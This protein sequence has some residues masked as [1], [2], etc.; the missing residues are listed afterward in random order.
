M[1][2]LFCTG[3]IGEFGGIER[4][5]IVK[6]NAF[7]EALGTENVAIC[8]TDRGYYPTTIHPLSPGIKVYDL[9]TPYWQFA[10]TGALLKGIIPNVLRTRKAIINVVRDFQPDVI[11]ST[12]SYEKFALALIPKSSLRDLTGK[13][14]IKVREFHFNSNYRSIWASSP[15]IKIYARLAESFE[16]HVLPRFYDKSFLLTKSDLTENM[17]NQ[18][19]RFDY[20][21]NPT[22]FQTY[23][24]TNKIDN[25]TVIAVGRFVYQ[26]NFEALIEIWHDV[27]KIHP[28][29]KLRIVGEGALRK[30]YEQL[31]ASLGLTE[32]VELP[33]YSS[34]V[35]SE[36]MK[37]S[38]YAMTSQYEGFG[39]VLL[40]AQSCG[41]PIVSYDLPYG[42][43]EIV[44]NNKDGFIVANKDKKAFA[45]ALNTLIENAELREKMGCNATKNVE[46]FAPDRIINQWL[47]KYRELLD[48]CKN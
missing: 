35:A 7:A 13:T 2:I 22:S 46:R 28:D 30:K 26:K 11:I 34:D 25:K 16:K 29:W 5:T 36:M 3:S 14:A 6:A 12:G 19:D 44:T 9:K 4:V 31:I 10:S 20:M 15:T 40:E 42:P 32:S 27:Y 45:D 8:F 38:I 41:L 48:G 24:R 43:A 39:L 33:G 37:A 23:G 21:Y 17:K 47:K 1:R 18:K